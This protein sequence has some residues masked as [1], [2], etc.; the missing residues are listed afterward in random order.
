MR[1]QLIW[2]V[3]IVMLLA[4][5]IPAPTVK[6]QVYTV[7]VTAVPGTLYTG[8][9]TTL[10]AELFEDSIS[11]GDVTAGTVFTIEVDAGGSWADNVYTCEFPGDWMINGTYNSQDT[12]EV[13]GTT[14][15]HVDT[16]VTYIVVTAVPGTLYTGQTTTLTAEGF[17]VNDVSFGDITASTTFTIEAGAGGGFAGNIY[18]SENPGT[19]MINGTYNNPDTGQPV[20]NTTTIT[21]LP[22]VTVN[23]DIKPGSYPN[24]INPKSKGMLPIA[25]LGNGLDVKQ[26]DPAT[27]N[28]NGVTLAQ[29]AAKRKNKPPK[30]AFSYEDVNGDGILDMVVFFRVQD[31]KNAGLLIQGTTQLTLTGAL[32]DGTPIT[33]TDSIRIVPPQK[34]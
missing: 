11:L 17:D 5:M 1:K 32:N 9:T 25:I 10:T 30:L 33:G 34:S 26:I 29:R 24:S 14:T 31:L 21:V 27:I 4:A 2:T 13:V 7:E 19:W 23:I 22:P 18:T 8:Q 20:K 12:G 28:I 16:T 6:A 3:L 15:I